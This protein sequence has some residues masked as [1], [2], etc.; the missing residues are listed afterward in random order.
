M[1]RLALGG[2]A[3]STLVMLTLSLT[4]TFSAMPEDSMAPSQIVGM[5]LVALI[6]G[7]V[8]FSSVSSAR[9]YV[10][11]FEL[12]PKSNL[13][14]VR[15]AGLWH[16]TTCLIPWQD[17]KANR[18]VVSSHPRDP[19]LRTHLRSGKRLSFEAHT[20]EAPRGWTALQ[21]FVENCDLPA[22]DHADHE[23]TPEC[24]GQRTTAFDQAFA[25]HRV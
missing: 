18:S 21:G 16:E 4:A 3:L 1:R 20:G 11:H 9:R 17:F 19:Y 5:L 8:G 13:V 22:E 12:W 6:T 15:T 23:P 2:L 10:V 14:L 7:V 24:A 25:P